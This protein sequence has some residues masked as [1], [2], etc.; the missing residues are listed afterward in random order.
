MEETRNKSKHLIGDILKQFDDKIENIDFLS[1]NIEKGA[2]NFTITKSKERKQNCT[3]ENVIFKEIYMNKIRKICANLSNSYVNNNSIIKKL[4]NNEFQPHKL[5]FMSPQDLYP[6]HWEKIIADKEKKD[7]MMCEIDFGQATTQFR[8]PRCK[9]NET[10]YYTLQTRSA[11]ESE[12]I[13]ITCLNCGKR[14]RK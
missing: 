9:N 10:T 7:S 5:A 1:R 2:F 12:T 3:W 4:V 8:C 6:E 13:F 14:W 11:D